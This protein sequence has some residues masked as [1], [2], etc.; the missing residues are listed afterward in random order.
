MALREKHW[1]ALAT[2]AMA[3]ACDEPVESRVLP[4]VSVVD[5]VEVASLAW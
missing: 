2:L 1:T 3:M 5:G 4:A